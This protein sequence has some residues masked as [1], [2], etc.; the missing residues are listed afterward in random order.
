VSWPSIARRSLCPWSGSPSTRGACNVAAS[1]QLEEAATKP[2]R[3]SARAG[4]VTDAAHAPRGPSAGKAERSVT[5]RVPSVQTSVL[6]P[7][8]LWDRLATLAS[9]TAG[10][11]T[12][13][14]LLV[15]ILHAKAA[16]TTQQAAED[17][18]QFLCLPC[19][20]TV[21]ER[22]EE[23]NIRLPAELRDRLD[24]HRRKFASA[25][26]RDATCAH[27]VAATI[28]LRG[29]TTAEQA[30]ELMAERRAEGF[31]RALE[32]SQAE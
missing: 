18:E 28:I 25:G 9:E 26:V 5:R 14:R 8:F 19:E 1:D 20:R 15:D 31:R 7:G 3:P 24:E 4:A 23:R 27:L 2:R 16:V 29:P 12:P 17:L 13:N 21:G 22:W 10:L 6:L 30:R 11:A 32:S